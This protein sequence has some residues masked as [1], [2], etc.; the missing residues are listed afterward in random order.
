M[1]LKDI[2]EIHPGHL[3]RAK[4]EPN[5][6]GSYWLIQGRD[7]DAGIL[8]CEKSDLVRFDPEI[9]PRDILLEDGDV[10]FMARG[11]KNYAALLANV[12]EKT[13]AAASFFIVRVSAE[14]IDPAYVVWYLNQPKAQHYFTQNS[15]RGVHMPVVRRSVIE[16]IDIPLPTLAIQKAIAELYRLTLDEQLMTKTLLAKRSELMEAVCLQAA[17]REDS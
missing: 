1:K 13:F 11:A 14:N 15:G 3:N 2:A 5:D 9:S 6:N 7:V 8:Q 12:P 4:I 17:E 16:D 10:M